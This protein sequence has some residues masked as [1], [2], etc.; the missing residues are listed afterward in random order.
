LIVFVNAV[1]EEVM[2]VDTDVFDGGI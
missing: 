1:C 2:F